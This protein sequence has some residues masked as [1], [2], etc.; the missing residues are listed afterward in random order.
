MSLNLTPLAQAI[1]TAFTKITIQE[2]SFYTLFPKFKIS[3]PIYRWITGTVKIPGHPLVSHTTVSHSLAPPL[4]YYE[5]KIPFSWSQY[6]IPRFGVLAFTAKPSIYTKWEVVFSPWNSQ[7]DHG[8]KN[9]NWMNLY[10]I[11]YFSP[12][13]VLESILWEA[14]ENGH[15]PATV[16]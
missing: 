3:Y 16:V 8:F 9:I 5:I 6:G 4:G 1:D 11:D 15:L 2:S 14:F 12:I 10:Y 13:Y 7:G